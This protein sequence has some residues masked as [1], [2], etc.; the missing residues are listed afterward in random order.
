MH[1]FWSCH[2]VA[3]TIANSQQVSAIL[4]KI[5]S[6]TT[7]EGLKSKIF[8]GVACPQIPLVGTL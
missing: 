2:G 4:L 8:L 5:A 7:S 6:E 3:H 1:V